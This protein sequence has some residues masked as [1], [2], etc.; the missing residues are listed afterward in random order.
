MSDGEVGGRK[1]MSVF[2]DPRVDRV[3]TWVLIVAMGIIGFFI[4]DV[5]TTVR[6]KQDESTKSMSLFMQQFSSVQID[7]AVL[8][9]QFA[10]YSNVSDRLDKVDARFQSIERMLYEMKGK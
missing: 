7:I 6:E 8:K 3:I 1:A 4:R 2:K 9:T 10:N 5:L